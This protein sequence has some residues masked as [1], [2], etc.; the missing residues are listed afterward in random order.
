[1]T[2]EEIK[3]EFKT[4]RYKLNQNLEKQY[5]NKKG[6][7]FNQEIFDYISNRYDDSSCF[8]ESLYRIILGIDEHPRC[9]MCGN[10]VPFKKD[11]SHGIF[12]DCCSS[13]CSHRLSCKN[14]ITEESI[15]KAK[16]TREKTLISR[17][18]VSNTFQ[19]PEI[20]SR[21]IKKHI[22]Y[23]KT[24]E[25][26]KKKKESTKKT[27]DYFMSKYGCNPNCLEDIKKKR[28]ET[29]R[30]NNTFSCSKP[31]EDLYYFIK[32]KFS[33]TRRQYRCARYPWACDFYIPELD[34]F[35]EF[36]GNWTH[37][38]H[39][40]DANSKTDQMTLEEWKSKS[41]EHPYYANA[42]NTWT[43]RDLLK[44]N[45][46]LSNKLNFHEF[47]NVQDAKHFISTL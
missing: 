24:E 39:P 34:C 28:Y 25:F 37:G 27:N 44:R 12:N 31:E 46:A 16:T 45:T 42:I 2:D 43:N 22:E 5:V 36:Q 8:L 17:Y 19:I 9:K 11:I 32:S 38:K 21:I 47:W 23:Y 30:R 29:K 18:G 4:N 6:N 20:K 40:F 15:R 14:G 3:N 13:S 41:E 7:R 26:K 35:I 33:S 1:M 10:L